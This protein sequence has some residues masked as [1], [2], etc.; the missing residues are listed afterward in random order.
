MKPTVFKKPKV[1]PVVATVSEP[2]ENS[3]TNP[4]E[5]VKE[6]R[7]LESIYSYR[8]AL[9]K[10]EYKTVVTHLERTGDPGW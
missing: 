1:K 3:K 7:E 10:F 6:E 8:S 4:G 2:T 5:D 9:N